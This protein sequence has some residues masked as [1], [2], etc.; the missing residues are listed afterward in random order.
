M[1]SR[2]ITFVIADL[3]WRSR[4]KR[5]AELTLEVAKLVEEHREPRKNLVEEFVVR[6]T[7]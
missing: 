2:F 5:R 4:G 6:V 7:A 3:F 1:G